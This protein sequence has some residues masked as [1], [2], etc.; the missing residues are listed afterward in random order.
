MPPGM[1][2]PSNVGRLSVDLRFQQG[3]KP[4]LKEWSL[5]GL[6]EYVQRKSTLSGTRAE[7]IAR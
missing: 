4:S 7:N 5:E 3:P 1:Y 2:T 6:D